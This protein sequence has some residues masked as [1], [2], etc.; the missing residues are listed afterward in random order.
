G[1][2]PGRGTGPGMRP[3]GGTGRGRGVGRGDGPMM[4]TP[5]GVQGRRGPGAVDGR[6]FAA[7]RARR[8]AMA[9]ANADEIGRLSQA[10]RPF[11]ESLDADQRALL[12]VLVREL[13]GFDAGPRHGGRDAHPHHG[14]YRR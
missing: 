14:R 6:D 3:G 11:W 9:S 12:P 2:G 7:R 5:G 8:A 1:A 13:G 10:M 4:M